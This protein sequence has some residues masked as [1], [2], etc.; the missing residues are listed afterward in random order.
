MGRSP[1]IQFRESR[2]GSRGSNTSSISTDTVGCRTR[3]AIHFGGLPSGPVCSSTVGTL[4]VATAFGSTAP[5]LYAPEPRSTG[6]WKYSNR[7]TRLYSLVGVEAALRTDCL[8]ARLRIQEK[9]AHLADVFQLDLFPTCEAGEDGCGCEELQGIS[10]TA[11][12]Q[13]NIGDNG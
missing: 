11:C 9:L 10:V 2:W 8:R 5:S 7:L 12:Q 4:S 1:P 13:S 3:S 6:L